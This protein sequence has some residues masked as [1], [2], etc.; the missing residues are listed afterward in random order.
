M[1]MRG[2]GASTGAELV[3]PAAEQW[4][5]A[6]ARLQADEFR[7]PHTEAPRIHAATPAGQST[8]DHL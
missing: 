5:T 4:L 8:S 6:K 2:S 3:G 1:L 7:V